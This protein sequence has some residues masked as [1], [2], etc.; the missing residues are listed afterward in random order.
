MH[1]P[2]RKGLESCET[3]TA[4][5]EAT[6]QT[7]WAIAKRL[8]NRDEP[9]ALTAIHG[10]L[11]LKFFPLEK[12]NTIADCLEKYFTPHNLCGVNHER[13]V[14]TRVQALF[15]AADND[16]PPMNYRK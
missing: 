10:P 11:S 3:K 12:A 8:I 14:E 5:T 1:D 15:E 4:I 13:W 7:I 16:P 6:P 9:R 2:Y